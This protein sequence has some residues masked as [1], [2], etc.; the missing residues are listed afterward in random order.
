M[1]GVRNDLGGKEKE[2]RSKKTESRLDIAIMHLCKIMP[3]Y[4]YKYILR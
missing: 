1:L 2:E 3:M 4:I